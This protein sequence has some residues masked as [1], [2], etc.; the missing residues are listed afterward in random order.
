[1]TEELASVEGTG[2][3]QV[4][5]ATPGHDRPRDSAKLGGVNCLRVLLTVMAIWCLGLPGVSAVEISRGPLVQPTPTN[6]V[7]QWTTDT[8]AGGRVYFG[9]SVKQ[10]DRR[11][12][13]D[14]VGTEHSVVL[15]GLKP[16]TTYWYT[17][18]TARL[19]LA[20][21]SFTAPGLSEARTES[22]AARPVVSAPVVR[23]EVP[24]SVVPPVAKAAFDPSK[25]QVPPAR[26]TWGAPRSLADHF[27]RHGADF[28]ARTADDYAAQAWIFL[29][30][31]KAE[32]LPAKRDEEG[33]LRV[34]DP[35]TR[36]FASYNRDLTTKTY[37]KP[38]RRDYFDDQP[39]QPVDLNKLVP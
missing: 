2:G 10:M 31:A 35:K 6:A 15:T 21:N 17:V 23:P 9:L 39:G 26:Q 38:G 36:A 22:P 11:A 27:E 13:A 4:T 32:G 25:L 24:K 7:I 12:N 29:R 20:T 30:R 33:V 5:S 18:G 19:A 28:A 3:A 37:F 34:Y 14:A 16:G 8:S 1:M